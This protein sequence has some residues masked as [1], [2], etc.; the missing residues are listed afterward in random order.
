MPE[1]GKQRAEKNNLR[2]A[3]AH[4]SYSK[5]WLLR[6][7]KQTFFPLNSYTKKQFLCFPLGGANTVAAQWKIDTINSKGIIRIF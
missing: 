1:G 3:T 7:L 4:S 6:W 2:L 5:T